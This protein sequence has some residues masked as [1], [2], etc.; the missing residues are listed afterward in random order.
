MKILYLCPDLGI[1][2]LGRKGAAVHVREMVAAFERASHKVVLAAQM[3]NKSPWEKSAQIETPVL[4]VRPSSSAGAAVLT[5]KE[6]NELIGVENSAPGELRR[7]LYNKELEVELTRRFEND[8]PDFIYERGSIYATA[9]VCLARN[10]GV[11]LIVELNAPLAVEQNAYRATSLGTLSA[12]TER[13][14][15][16][17]ADALVVVSSELRQ[18]VVSL[19]IESARIHVL[20][21][22]VNAAQFHP[23]P[24]DEVLRSRMNLDGGAVIGFVG[25]LRPW[26]GAEVLPE[27]LERLASKYPKARLVIAGDGPLRGELERGL[28]QRGLRSRTVITGLLSHEEIPPLIRQFDVALAPYS[29][30]DHPFYFSPLK[31]FEYMACGV[32]VVAA[33]LGQ[34]A[35]I[36]RDGETGLLYPPGDTEALAERCARL[37]ENDVLRKEIGRAAANLVHNRFTWDK[38]AQYISKLANELISA[39]TECSNPNTEKTEVK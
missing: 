26:H 30:L 22:G 13:W 29:R 12:Q 10:L 23:A 2:V 14:T 6:F 7:I 36:V 24:H 25:G 20:P 27:L 28:E 18:H 37:L 38:N 19:G 21:N 34:I 9:G 11:P 16:Q 17:K 8:P 33:G 1:P 4:Q 5:L 3:L 39:K 15:L 32:A 31:L 35:E